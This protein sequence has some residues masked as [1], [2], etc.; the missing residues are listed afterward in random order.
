MSEGRATDQERALM[1]SREVVDSAPRT[2]VYIPGKQAVSSGVGRVFRDGDAVVVIGGLD[3]VQKTQMGVVE[4][5]GN[6]A[7]RFQD[8]ETYEHVQALAFERNP[9][10]YARVV[11]ILGVDD[12]ARTA[13]QLPAGVNIPRPE[14]VQREAV[15]EMAEPAPSSR[16]T[17]G[18]LL[19]AE[20][21]HG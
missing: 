19:P 10:L 20:A 18:F 16:R 14:P 13:P 1:L 8:V 11:G 15:E 12:N 9:A 21:A 7:A 2:L 17:V 6:F 5:S 4:F 3:H